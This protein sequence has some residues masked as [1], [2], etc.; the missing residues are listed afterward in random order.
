MDVPLAMEVEGSGCWRAGS[1][2]TR[3]EQQARVQAS[4][5]E[6]LFSELMK[7]VRV[8]EMIPAVK[9]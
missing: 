8:P 2:V 9:H 7:S 3:E 1:A 6:V 4:G 5:N